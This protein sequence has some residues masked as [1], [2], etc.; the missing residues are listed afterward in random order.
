MV[1]G[2]RSAGEREGLGA[3]L[4]CNRRFAAGQGAFQKPASDGVDG[5]IAAIGEDDDTDWV[6]RRETD[7]GAAVVAAAIFFEIATV[8]ES[9]RPAEGMVGV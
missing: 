8:D 3:K 7:P 9:Q 1:A 4:F 5:G 2:G 6:V